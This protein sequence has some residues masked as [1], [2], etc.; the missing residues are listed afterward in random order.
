[1]DN[2]DPARELAEAILPVPPGHYV[3]II[4]A[5]TGTGIAEEAKERIFDPYFTTK[6]VGKGT[7]MGLAVVHGILKSYAGGMVLQTRPGAGTRF[8]IYFPLS[9]EPA[10]ESGPHVPDAPNGNERILFVD[11]ESM[12]VDLAEKCLARLGYQV[13]SCTDPVEAMNL[14]TGGECPIDL[15]IS[16][17]TMHGMSGV[18]LAHKIRAVNPAVPIILCTGDRERIPKNQLTDLQVVDVL[19][20]PVEFSTLAAAVRRVFDNRDS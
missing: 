15:L 20:K 2:V 7:G 10:Q 16:D 5:D 17:M 13:K 4:V 9:G 11:D 6:K 12:I 1:M 8:E 18:Q 14:V 3:R 19:D